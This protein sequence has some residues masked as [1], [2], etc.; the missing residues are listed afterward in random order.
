MEQEFTFKIT[1]KEADIL[2][3]ALMELPFKKVADTFFK[4][5]NQLVEAIPQAQ[6]QAEGEKA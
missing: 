5:R 1:S 6:P 3:E 2:M 4:I